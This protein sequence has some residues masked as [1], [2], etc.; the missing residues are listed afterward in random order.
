MWI[1]LSDFLRDAP[2]EIILHKV[3]RR[4]DHSAV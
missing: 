2:V 4:Y 3:Q 1:K